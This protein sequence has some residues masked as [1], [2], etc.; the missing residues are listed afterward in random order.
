M[1]TLSNYL[2]HEN[3]SLY[4][5]KLLDILSKREWSLNE[6]CKKISLRD[7]TI[8]KFLNDQDIRMDTFHKIKNFVDKEE[9]EQ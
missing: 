9:K 1:N 4:R 2:S 8:K 3:K 5:K 6:L 7:V